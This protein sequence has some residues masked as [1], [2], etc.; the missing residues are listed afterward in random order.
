VVK[1]RQTS[2]AA[3]EWPPGLWGRSDLDRFGSAAK[4]LRN[5]FVSRHGVPVSRPG[6]EMKHLVLPIGGQ[7][8]VGYPC[9]FPNGD[10]LLVVLLDYRMK[11][12]RLN[13]TTGA[14]DLAAGNVVTPYPSS[15]LRQLRFSQ[16][17][18]VITI[19][20]PQYDPQRLVHDPAGY[21]AWWN[22]DPVDF[23]VPPWPDWFPGPYL[24][25][26]LPSADP[27]H[28][29][30]YWRWAI[31]CI[32][33]T[34]DG[35]TYET[36]PYEIG[37]RCYPDAEEW[38]A[39][40]D[41]VAAPYG[42]VEHVV[43]LPGLSGY[44]YWA[45]M[46]SGPNKPAGPQEPVAG[47]TTAF[48]VAWTPENLYAAGE[49]WAMTSAQEYEGTVPPGVAL[50][51]DQPVTVRW[52]DFPRW[53]TV[54]SGA[55]TI[56]AM[57]IYRGQHE[58]WGYVGQV[59]LSEENKFVDAGAEPDFARPPPQ[60]TNPF[61]IYNA[62][63]TWN[64]NQHPRLS[65]YFEGRMIFAA[66]DEN[67]G[68]IWGSAVDDL[69]N[70]D[71]VIPAGDADAFHFGIRGKEDES[72]RALLPRQNLIVLGRKNEYLVS[73]SGE[74]EI[75][76]PN[77][78]A[79]HPVSK[80]GCAELAPLEARDVVLF[81][82]AKATIPRCI[83]L[84]S[85][86]G[87]EGIVDLSTY[88]THLFEGHTIT[89]WCYA[90]DP[91][92]LILAARDDG[93]LL[94]LQWDR[95]QEMLAWT[96]WELAGVAQVLDVLSLPE[97]TEDAIWV[98]T[99]RQT[100]GP[101]YLERFAKRAAS[102]DEDV[103]EQICL[104][105]AVT[106]DGRNTDAAKTVEILT[107]GNALIGCDNCI[108][109]SPDG[110]TWSSVSVIGSWDG[111]AVSP[112]GIAVAVGSSATI[113]RSQDGGATWQVQ[114]AAVGFTGD[115]SRVAYGD[116]LWVAV[117][118]SG[119]IQVSS[120]GVTWIRHNIAGETN[121][122]YGVAYGNGLWV[123]VGY[124]SI[125]TS[126]DGISWQKQTPGTGGGV[127]PDAEYQDVAYGDGTFVV[128]GN[129]EIQTSTDGETWYLR[130]QGFGD[131]LKACTFGNGVWVAVG[132][133]SA[134]YRSPTGILWSKEPAAGITDFRDVTWGED[135]ALFIAT[136]TSI[137]LCGLQTSANG[138]SWTVQTPGGGYGATI[139]EAAWMPRQ[140]GRY[141]TLKV[142]VVGEAVAGEHIGCRLRVWDSAGYSADV[143]LQSHDGGGIY[144]AQT[145][146]DIPAELDRIALSTWA[147]VVDEVAGLDHIPDG[148]AVKALVDGTVVD[149]LT[150]AAGH[151]ALPA[152][153]ALIHAG[154]PYNC[155]FESLPLIDP[156]GRKLN[157]THVAVEIDTARS[158]QVGQD[159]DHLTPLRVRDVSGAS[160]AA[161]LRRIE[162]EVPVSG[163]WAETGEVAFRQS[164]PLPVTI[165]AIRRTVAVGGK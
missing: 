46:D 25:E 74:G 93:M 48:W 123:A 14:L 19:T 162:A 2:F 155:D 164:D 108:Q 73:G 106:V 11:A 20:S 27:T 86:G 9:T 146:T 102:N 58:R 122:L 52:G 115:F 116:G 78:I 90:E 55:D 117:G 60:G 100:N 110:I 120:D 112:D 65:D 163:A 105:G 61:S 94:V 67:P 121:W 30:T 109:Y 156:E 56:T 119:E 34:A 42:S 39:N 89:R 148:T 165:L 87:I 79:I 84:N 134:I 111:L 88:S 129:E 103:A 131:N 22:L 13:P 125:Y 128:V 75:L 140:R 124:L 36:L 132:N 76:T 49:T 68:D 8:A 127:V 69:A 136:G 160:T 80:W 92:H 33:Q 107:P 5:F 15:A 16:L 51:A 133:T 81:L 98:L 44:Y 96:P 141:I 82:Q 41:Y 77:G 153:G 43:W 50:Y 31:T 101:I 1:P 135:T 157:I 18:D 23:S 158:G 154:L 91:W 63:G 62:D 142:V 12:Y 152:Y 83:V 57:R 37:R 53:Y 35:E 99:R 97:G 150:V 64:H 118:Q 47:T 130:Y 45:A 21:G 24:V 145:Q 137:C 149:G 10:I 54:P 161:P 26:P 7:D 17:G 4:T 3:G 151:V 114:S 126:P 144:T 6:L 104:D 95:R 29:V 59:G 71:V 70:H 66:S 40:H 38:N 138:E 143:L 113:V 32:M 159:L 139:R 28:P 72:I 147:V 85:D